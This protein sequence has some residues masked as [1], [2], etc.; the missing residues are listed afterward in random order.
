MN[1]VITGASRGIGFELAKRFASLSNHSILAI[2][3]DAE[4]LRELKSA[5]IRE[6]IEA[7]LH[8]LP[9]DLNRFENYNDTLLKSIKA[10]FSKIDILINNAGCLIKKPFIQITDEDVSEMMNVNV[11]SPLRLIRLLLPLMGQ[12]SHVVNIS[13]MG[14][15]QGSVKFPE[16]SVYSATKSALAC[17]TECLALEMKDTGISFN[18]L[19]LG[20]VETEMLKQ[21]FPDYKAPLSAAEMAKFIAD[22]ALTG[23]QFFN[24][25]VLPISIS[26]P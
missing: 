18:C 24:G 10:N 13:S 11:L 21:A 23:N 4:K 20:A 6:N 7:H 26:T 9:F 2:A 12:G 5:C 22:F 15:F 25:K 17:L 16:L 3:R 8:P 19:A 14:G 1:I